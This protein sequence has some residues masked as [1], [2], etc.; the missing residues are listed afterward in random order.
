L[1]VLVA[2]WCFDLSGRARCYDTLSRLGHAGLG[3]RRL[4][5][6]ATLTLDKVDGGFAITTIVLD[7]VASLDSSD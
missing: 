1:P 2:S 7:V 3:P 5:T 6:K 4:D